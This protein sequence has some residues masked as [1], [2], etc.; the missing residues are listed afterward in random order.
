MFTG[1]PFA[2]SAN[3]VLISGQTDAV[4]VD[5]QFIKDDVEVFVDF[6]KSTGKAL[7]AIVITHA[8]P[9]HYG[10]MNR[11]RH[12][13]P[14]TPLLARSG[15]IDGI[16]EW[17]AKRVHWQEMYAGQIPDEM[18]LPSPL[19]GGL[20]ML[21]DREIL[22]VDLPVCETVH[23]TAFY[24]PSAK[25]FVTGDLVFNRFHGYMADTNNPTSWISG[26]EMARNLGPID[27]VFPGHGVIGGPELFQAQIGWLEAYREIAKPGVPVRIIAT[28]MT[29]RFPDFGLPLLLWLTRGPGFGLHGWKEL[30][31]PPALMGA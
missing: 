29:E 27:H 11:F 6:V 18:V 2:L 7:R 28:K 9:D 22:I 25:V 21:E 8:H 17:P 13:W 20:L 10:G 23:A 19:R 1:A 14:E 31:V 24:V 4:L 12:A 3:A 16:R 30:G 5:T 26:I 15:V